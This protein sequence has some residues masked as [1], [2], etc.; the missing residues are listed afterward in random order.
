MKFTITENEADQRF[1][2]FL[3]KY[4][5][6][7]KEIK[8]TDIFL[9]IRKWAIKVNGKKRA[10]KWRLQRDDIITWDDT[11]LTEKSAKN[12][13][14]NKAKKLKDYPLEK[15][16]EILIHE[17]EHRLVFN[18]P[19]DIVM[20][21]WTWHTNDVCLNDML[22]I[23]IKATSYKLQVE[24]LKNK[25]DNLKP[26]IS[27]L[28][29]PF[30]PSFCFRLDRDTSGIIIA[31]KTY[32]ALQY[33]NEQIRERKTTKQ[34]LAIVN[35]IFPKEKTIDTP[36]FKWFDKK[37]GRAKVFVNHEQGQSAKT[38]AHLLKHI[39]HPKLGDISL[40]K[41]K[42]YTGRMHQIRVHLA[43][44]WYSIIWD[45]MYGI[46]AINRI[47]SKQAHINRQLLHSWKYWFFD[48]FMHKQ[49]SFETEMPDIFF[50]LF[51]ITH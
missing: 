11:I 7:Q 34:Y 2:R 51:P 48:I 42:I 13:K 35:G 19:A 29:S 25:Q 47:A 45:I 30:S 36:L 49:V 26:Q 41:V 8:L 1:D 20:H 10:E 3:R 38:T 9:R 12:F 16:Q 18:K 14:K 40:L 28:K 43:S 4:F 46:P 17:D 50:D 24:S 21:W 22:K 27:S 15:I 31:A 6:A 39:E 5:K 44:I 37:T 33:L 23:Y 32:P